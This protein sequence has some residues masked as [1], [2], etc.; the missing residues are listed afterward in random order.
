[1]SSNT[2]SLDD[3]ADH[4]IDT[5]KHFLHVDTLA[6]ATANGTGS[7][8]LRAFSRHE[9]SNPNST[10]NTLLQSYSTLVLH[11]TAPLLSIPNIHDDQRTASLPITQQLEA[12][13][14][15]G[16][17]VST[18]DHHPVG[19][20]CA[21]HH[22]TI[23]FTEQ[24]LAFFESMAAFFGYILDLENASV[25]DSLTGLYNRRYLSHLY[26]NSS[27]KQFSVMFIDIDDFKDVNDTFG[28]DFGDAL[29][30]QIASRLKQSVRKSDILVRYGGDE[31]VICFQHLVDNQD[32]DFV[33][34]KIKDSINEP[35]MIEG[36]SISISASVGIS[37]K[38]GAGSSLK[39]LISDADQAMYGIKQNE[40]NL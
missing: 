14:F 34:K 16:I 38:H 24:Q 19:A 3:A 1:M 12:T 6:V 36:H 11:H 15:I 22:E 29:L 23:R 39:E 26:Q 13:S 20:I 27:D 33:A 8:I 31:F 9:T 30:L 32:I 17:A 21:W 4:I 5:L 10:H 2:R 40:K 35:F 18:S 37:A 28:H 25:T 7:R